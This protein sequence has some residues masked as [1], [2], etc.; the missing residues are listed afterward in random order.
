MR[1][2]CVGGSG[3][4]LTSTLRKAIWIDLPFREISG[5]DACSLAMH[6][7]PTEGASQ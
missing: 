4:K 1:D 6:T 7:Y 3:T 5:P 2:I